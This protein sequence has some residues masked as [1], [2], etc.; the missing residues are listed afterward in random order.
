[1]SGAFMIADPPPDAPRFGDLLGQHRRAAG[2][3]QEALAEQAGLSVRGISDLER[4]IRTHPQRETAR[5]LADAL[6]LVGPERAALLASARRPP[7]S[8]SSRPAVH[9]LA[10][11]S[12]SLAARLPVFPGSF[13]G[14]ATEIT[15]IR[16]LLADGGPHLVTLTG[17]GGTGKTRLAVAI[18]TALRDDYPDGAGFV[19]LSPLSDPTLV[20]PRIASSLGVPEVAGEPLTETL[21]RHLESRSLLLVLDNCEQVLGAAPEIG[22][23]AAACPQ[24]TLLATSREPLRVRAEQVFPVSPL[25]LPEAP[26]L[27]LAEQAAVPAIALF[28]E[29]AR[30][31]DP[32]FDLTPQ[33]AAAVVAICRRLDGL[34][35]AIELAA[36]RMR[37]LPPRALLA[38]LDHS[39]PILAGGARDLP[40]R[41]RTLRTTI[42]WSYDLLDSDEQRLFRRLG[43]FT[44]G[45][46][47]ATAEA[48]AGCDGDL[49]V[50]TGMASLVDKSLVGLVDGDNEHPRYRMLETIR[51]FAAEQ[52]ADDP[53]GN[54]VRQA[55]LDAM[56]HLALEND[57]FD[58]GPPFEGRL[59]RLVA[60]EAN[61]RSALEWALHANPDDAL[62]LTAS[63]RSYWWEQSRPVVGLDVCERV[64]ATG[65]GPETPE[66]AWVLVVTS[67][68]ALTS[69][70]HPRADFLADAALTL[71]E[72]LGEDRLVA[73]A[74]F[75]QGTIAI[76]RTDLSHATHLLEDALARFESLG[77]VWGASNCLNH[78][79][80]N[81]LNQGDAASAASFFERFLADAVEHRG[82]KTKRAV[83]LGNL[84]GAYRVLG[85]RDA[86]LE[87]STEA[88]DLAD[89]SGNVGLIAVTRGMLSL[90][91]LDRGEIGRAASLAGDALTIS[92]E[93]GDPWGVPNS[94][95]VT[96][97]VM[98]AGQRA[99]SATRVYGA[100]FALRAASGIP[101]SG[102]DRTEVERDLASLRAVLS[103]MA[104]AHA[105]A[106]GERLS[107]DD[108]VELALPALAELA[109]E[110]G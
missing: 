12:G 103:E 81:A 23:L 51:E 8:R 10:P 74:L 35:L 101:I 63:L 105:W 83:A 3:T 65:A 82:S 14:R 52:L 17:P 30:A 20:V 13:V 41:Q 38:H 34:P 71:A 32:A 100:A 2:L 91:A 68:Y 97:A 64:L 106:V 11:R 86:A 72:R 9:A 50:L 108:A 43:V 61:L 69:G 89:A 47:L 55:H 107:P 98:S 26:D 1:M 4:G 109:S 70:D 49:D 45:W 5:M 78:L 84:A 56:L 27:A 87:L 66:R 16:A 18:A 80:I 48:V 59:A 58:H 88:L 15:A 75:C 110:E 46:T 79:G 40:E 37:V 31:S 104:F 95:E 25:A 92:W 90:L 57:L 76:N 99:E 60:E 6:H 28:V 29:R 44:G 67:W 22:G 42:A 33:N 93:I 62:R 21:A 36:A 96:A 24:L 85:Q 94:L 7:G 73:S 77:D 102:C 54:R 53:A 19:D 39:L